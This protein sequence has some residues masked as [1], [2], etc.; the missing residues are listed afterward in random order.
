MTTERE[1]IDFDYYLII[2]NGLLQFNL[3]YYFMFL[4]Y[5]LINNRIGGVMISVLASSVVDDGFKPLI[6]Q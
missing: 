3:W 4:I 2:N 1:I 5:S 6:V